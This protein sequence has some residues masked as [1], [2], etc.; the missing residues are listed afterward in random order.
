LHIFAGLSKMLAVL[1]TY[2]NSANTHT[3]AHAHAHAH[4]HTHSSV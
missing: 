3:H 2:Y 4:A 1:S